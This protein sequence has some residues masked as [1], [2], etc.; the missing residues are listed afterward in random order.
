[1][2]AILRS[3]DPGS[4]L[5]LGPVPGPARRR[6][7]QRGITTVLR[8]RNEADALPWSLP[9]VLRATAEV[10]LVDNGSTD[11][12]PDVAREVA[13]DLGLSDR[14]RVLDYPALISRCG[15]EHLATPP[16][17]P[18]SLVHFNNWA[19]DHVETTYGLKWDGDM[20]LTPEGEAMLA[21]LAWQIGRHRVT[22]RLP[23]HPLYVASDQVAYLDLGLHNVE[24]YGHPVRDEFSYV[25]AFEWEFLKFPANSGAYTLPA[26]VCLE[27]K[28]IHADEFEHWTDPSAFA[29]SPRTPRKRREYDV[30]RAIVDGTWQLREHVH[31]IESPAGTHV[32]D[33][34]MEWLR[35]APR[36]LVRDHQANAS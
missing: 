3:L 7:D 10:V 1:M 15:P 14:L 32:V 34:V 9:P 33:H 18:N 2:T 36:P 21:D 6:P 8:V 11:G 24:H 19:F 28:R 26:G 17:S 13:A 31:R 22:V 30:F 23:R 4:D 25:K 16:G 5:D 20:V 12:T 29:T 27:L 35:T